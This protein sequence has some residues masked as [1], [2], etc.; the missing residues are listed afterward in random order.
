MEQEYAKSPIEHS[1]LPPK[2]VLD[3]SDSF[4]DPPLSPKEGAY[5]T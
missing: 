1:G 4:L 5:S 2:I 3:G